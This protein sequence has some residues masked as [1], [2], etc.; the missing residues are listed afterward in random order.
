MQDKSNS[1]RIE[2]YKARLDALR[3][4]LREGEKSGIADYS[5]EEIIEELEKENLD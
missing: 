2:D 1:K 5:L 3:R 4:A